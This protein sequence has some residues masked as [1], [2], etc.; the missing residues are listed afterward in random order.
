MNS[1]KLVV[2]ASPIISLAQI[3]YADLLLRLTSQLVIPKGVFEEITAYRMDDEAV[4]WMRDKKRSLIHQ[5]EIPTKISEWNLGKGESEVIAF[6]YQQKEYVVSI[7]D[8]A[9][10]R[11]AESFDIKVRGTIALIIDA[12]RKQFIF[13]ATPLLLKLKANGFRI[14]SAVFDE[15]LKLAGES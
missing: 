8:R 9:A 12:K 5:V 14:S 7:D 3:G 2:N 13:E 11:C 6:A 15:A 1:T 10:K 4:L